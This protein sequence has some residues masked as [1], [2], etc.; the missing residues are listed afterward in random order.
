MRSVAEPLVKYVAAALSALVVITFAV[1]VFVPLSQ[2]RIPFNHYRTASVIGQI[3]TAEREYAARF[4]RAGFT[5]DLY[6]I[7]RDGDVPNKGAVSDLVFF[8][9]S[10]TGYRYELRGCEGSPVQRFSV[11]AVPQVPRQTGQFAFCAT[12]DGVIWFDENGLAD[13]CLRKQVAWAPGVGRMQRAL[14]LLLPITAAV[15]FAI[16]VVGKPRLYLRMMLIAIGI[17]LTANL[18]SVLRPTACYDCSFPYGLPFA[19]YRVT[20]WLKGQIIWTGLAANVAVVIITG[21]A[22]GWVVQS[23][24]R[25]TGHSCR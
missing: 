20:G 15:C 6:R 5:C 7:G 4:P 3:I 17:F 19:V 9:S 18:V 14:L 21:L 1:G 10:R 23:L 8:S 11:V 12:Q 24:S 2:P 13:N 22:I 16:A 25:K